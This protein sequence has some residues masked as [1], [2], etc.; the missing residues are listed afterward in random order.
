MIGMIDAMWRWFSAFQIVTLIVEH[1]GAGEASVDCY[2]IFLG[3]I[4]GGLFYF[5]FL[6]K[7][8]SVFRVAA[9]LLSM[10]SCYIHDTL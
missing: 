10:L 2:F 1:V 9:M 5:S 4:R 8:R 7:T 3:G 6:C